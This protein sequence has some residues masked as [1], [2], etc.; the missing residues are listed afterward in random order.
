MGTIEAGVNSLVHELA[1]SGRLLVQNP[2]GP[3]KDALLSPDHDRMVGRYSDLCRPP[4]ARPG[5]CHMR[6]KPHHSW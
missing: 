5:M 4:S 1:R 3:L 2:D 6:D